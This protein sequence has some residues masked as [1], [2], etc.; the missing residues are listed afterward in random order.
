MS[1][2]P[3]EN[4]Y[5]LYIQ[6]DAIKQRKYFFFFKTV[7]YEIKRKIKPFILREGSS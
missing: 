3:P 5:N 2:T 7:D 1:L 4:L 6:R